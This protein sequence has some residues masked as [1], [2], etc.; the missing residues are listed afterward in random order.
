MNYF[1]HGQP[2]FA[3]PLVNV[4][5]YPVPS[6]GSVKNYSR[7]LPVWL[8]QEV[9]NRPVDYFSR[10]IPV[11]CKN[12]PMAYIS[13]YVMKGTLPIAGARVVCLPEDCS[14][15]LGVTYSD[16]NGFY[17]FNVP[18]T[19]KYCLFTEYEINGQKYSSTNYWDIAPKED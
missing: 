9:D 3:Q 1:F 12:K 6:G 10:G 18:P 17:R 4:N 16:V 5:S 13:G 19:K 14:G 2:A 7:G 15:I 8:I 11:F